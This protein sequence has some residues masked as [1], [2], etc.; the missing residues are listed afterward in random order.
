MDTF[1][2][3]LKSS[4]VL[5]GDAA[6]QERAKLV[7]LEALNAYRNDFVRVKLEQKIAKAIGDQE[8]IKTVEG[9]VAKIVQQIE[10][11]EQEIEKL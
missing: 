9:I 11:V 5:D 7:L 1:V 6:V 10:L 3:E 2:D 4:G 8:R